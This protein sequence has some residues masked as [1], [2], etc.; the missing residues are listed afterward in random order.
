MRFRCEWTIGNSISDCPAITAASRQTLAGSRTGRERPPE[1]PI[2]VMPGP[3]GVGLGP[4]I[5]H[6]SRCERDSQ[7]AYSANGRVVRRHHG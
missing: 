5:A 1:P 2:E 7:G 3:F 6:R 4:E